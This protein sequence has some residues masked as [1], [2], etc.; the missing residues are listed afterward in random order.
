MIDNIR[1]LVHCIRTL[2]LSLGWRYWKVQNRSKQDPSLVMLWATRC[3]QEAVLMDQDGRQHL[4]V[5]Y[6][7][8]ACD[9]RTSYR[10]WMD[11]QIADPP[12]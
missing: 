2:G 11:Q 1:Q 10:L 4:A 8:W 7:A 12:C 5:Y 9:L 3:D 6:R